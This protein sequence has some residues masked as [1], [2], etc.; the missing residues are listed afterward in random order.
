MSFEITF[1]G[2]S[3]GPVEGITCSMLLKSSNVSYNEILSNNLANELICIDAGSGIG[4]LSELIYNEVHDISPQSK[5]LRMYNDMLSLEQCFKTK[6]T[7]P[8]AELS[9]SVSP[10]ER[11]QEIFKLMNNYLI[12][13]A[14]M[15]HI[16]ALVINS[17]GFCKESPK[18][19][20]GS[21]GT[22]DALQRHIFNGLVW[23]NMSKFNMVKLSPH[24]YWQTFSI[25]DTYSV[26]IFDL[27]HGNMVPHVEKTS[28]ISESPNYPRHTYDDN[29]ENYN[30]YV[31]S[32]FL[33]TNELFNSS[34]LIFGDFESDIISKLGKNKR[35]WCKIAPMLLQP[36]K[37]LKGIILECST[38]QIVSTNELYGHIMPTHL[39]NELRALNDEIL[40]LIPSS[41]RHN[42]T[43]LA[44]FNVVINHVKE[45]P[46]LSDPRR[47][48]LNELEILNNKYELGIH[49]SIALNG[50]SIVL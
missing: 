6:I 37:Q 33:V 50:A 36:E 8:F 9:T 7:R 17:A 41:N 10:Y 26:T 24:E 5:Q 11:A 34:V 42:M 44:G 48:I 28:Q 2:A 14:H 46:N 1:L 49:F 3:G 12:S 22:I 19:V 25:N 39:I 18:N 23:P 32:A 35:I 15:D 30:N 38:C 43:P 20:Y 31:S 27:S 13:H 4:L 40:A 29:F 47:E 45:T 16:A 21:K